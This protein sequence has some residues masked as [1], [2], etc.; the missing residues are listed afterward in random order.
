MYHVA[1]T[2]A[3]S[4]QNVCAENLPRAGSTTAPPVLSVDSKVAIRPWP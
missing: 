3:A 1:P 4:S 2:V